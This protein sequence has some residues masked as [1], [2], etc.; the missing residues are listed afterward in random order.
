MF[1]LLE[2]AAKQPQKCSFALWRSPGYDYDELC[3]SE[4]DFC[5]QEN[6]TKAITVSVM[7]PQQ[8]VSGFNGSIPGCKWRGQ[9][10]GCHYV[11]PRNDPYLHMR[12]GKTP[13][14]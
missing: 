12:S 9:P 13:S 14:P 1:R 10:L 8:F 2:R 7:T 11:V 5:A 3:H 6:A 4:E